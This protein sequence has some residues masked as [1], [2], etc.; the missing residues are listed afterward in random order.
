[1]HALRLCLGDRVETR[2]HGKVRGHAEKFMH[3]STRAFAKKI[4]KQGQHR[5]QGMFLWNIH[6]AVA[7]DAEAQGPAH[8]F[9]LA[10]T[11]C[12]LCHCG[13]LYVCYEDAMLKTRR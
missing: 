9:I 1:M 7:Q 8:R 11:A 6:G 2:N 10:G 3:L 4:G 12:N 5:F 13:L